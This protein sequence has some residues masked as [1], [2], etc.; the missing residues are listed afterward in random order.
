LSGIFG[1]VNRDGAPL[2]A[3]VLDALR[4]ETAYW[5]RD[6]GGALC[7]GAA[8]LGCA[9]SLNTPEAAFERMP[10][11]DSNGFM[12]TAAGRADNR[13]ELAGALGFRTDEVSRLADGALIYRAWLRWGDSVPERIFGDWAMAVW[14][15]A[16]RRLFLAR[17]HSGNTAIYYYVNPEFFAFSSSRRALLKL[18]LPPIEMDEL[19]LAQTLV[20]WP[21]DYG[22]R[23]VHKQV[24]RL[25]PSHHLAVTPERI[26]VRQ[27]WQLEDT[28]ERLLP[29]NDYIPAF[30]EIFD[31]A[32]LDR[33]RGDGP[34]GAMLSGGLDSSSVAVTAA[35][36]LREKGRRVSAFTSV[37]S[38]GTAA[39]T[40]HYFGDE[41]PFA[42]ATAQ[43][44]GNVDLTTVD[45]VGVCPI[46]AIRR[47][48][49]ISMEPR[50][51]AANLF[52]LLELRRMASE[53]GCR[54]LLCGQAGNISISWAGDFLSQPVLVQIRGLGWRRWLR[55]SIRRYAP[56]RVRRSLRRYQVK[57]Q[58]SRDTA[59]HPDFAERLDLMTRCLDDP[60]ESPAN[61]P[62]RQR[63]HALNPAISFS[64]AVQ[65]E[66]GTAAGLEISDPTADAR[67]LAFCLSVPDKIFINPETG[68]DRWLIREAMKGRLPESVRLNRRRGRQ[69]GDLVP[70]LR[71][72]ATAVEGA[73]VEIEGGPAV[74]YVSVPAMRRA[75]E[76]IR[77]EDT[78][79]AFGLAVAVLT[80]GIMAGLFVNGF[81][82]QW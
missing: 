15:P 82:T 4:V 78:P 40:G 12:F 1:V 28:P 2:A 22:E 56:Q 45:A 35:R 58:L 49:R 13:G 17:D 44:A 7:D 33:L 36:Y 34:A 74:S 5:G 67:V 66:M 57:Q 19:F 81:G 30:L 62:F 42:R 61:S 16:K 32:V 77:T 26:E 75:W 41:L 72:A 31:R 27:Y 48:L 51:A 63:F 9:I 68:A 14:N 11:V 71:N 8:G 79:E 43:A 10:L 76:K 39:Y 55:G 52:W 59:V 64:G 25:P 46:D 53:R 60:G 47:G 50:H 21:G 3:G 23:T 18:N 24:K 69:A 70:R 37:P 20:S 6:G 73:L 29:R 38:F 65:A 80:R 54:T